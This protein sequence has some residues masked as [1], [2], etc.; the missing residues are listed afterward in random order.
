MKKLNKQ[1]VDPE[2]LMK[3]TDQLMDLV[4]SLES[5]NIETVDLKQLEKEINLIEK[6]IK[7]KYKG[8]LPENT[9]DYLDSKE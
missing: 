7:E 4:S 6:N 3:D 8:I 5:M 9:Q 2:E 1:N